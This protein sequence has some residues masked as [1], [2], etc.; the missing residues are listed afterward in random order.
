M[1][2][3]RQNVDNPNL[4]N[5]ETKF[6]EVIQGALGTDDPGETLKTIAERLWD[7]VPR[8]RK[9]A[10][11]EELRTIVPDPAPQRLP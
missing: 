3:A 4:Y 2:W 1:S 7:A 11:A 9:H 5:T 8:D 6:A 10:L